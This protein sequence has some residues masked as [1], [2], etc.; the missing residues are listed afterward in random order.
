LTRSATS[1]TVRPLSCST[2]ALI[3]AILFVSVSSR[4]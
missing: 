3:S 4:A 1:K 2:I